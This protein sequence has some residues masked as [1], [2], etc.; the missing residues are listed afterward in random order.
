MREE[1]L[2]G[3]FSDFSVPCIWGS[4]SFDGIFD[5]PDELAAGGV[6]V[7]TEYTLLVKSNDIVGMRDGAVISVSGEQYEV[8]YARKIDD[9]KLTRLVLSKV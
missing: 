3:F 9:G 4:Y 5:A 7:S 2:R 6:V 1:E 8:R